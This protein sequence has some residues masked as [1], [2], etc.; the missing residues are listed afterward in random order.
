MTHLEP[1]RLVCPEDPA[2]SPPQASLMN[3][4]EGTP[5]NPPQRGTIVLFAG[6]T[7][8]TR[9]DMNGKQH[10]PLARCWPQDGDRS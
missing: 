10:A 5:P 1:G 2:G 9:R 4:A 3:A 8:L 6:A 7:L